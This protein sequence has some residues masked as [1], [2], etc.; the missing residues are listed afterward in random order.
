MTNI[1]NV[2]QQELRL[3]CLSAQSLL[4]NTLSPSPCASTLLMFSLSQNKINLKQTNTRASVRQHFSK[5][6]HLEALIKEC[7]AGQ[8]FNETHVEKY[9]PTIAVDNKV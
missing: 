9:Y 2:D 5:S 7:L 6:F 1:L 3:G 8:H 4:G